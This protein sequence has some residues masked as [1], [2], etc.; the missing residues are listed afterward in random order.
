VDPDPA[1]FV[2]S[3]QDANKKTNLKKV[4][5]LLLFECKFISFLKD[6]KVQKKLKTVRSKVFLAIL[7]GGPKEVKNSKNQGFSY[8]FA[9]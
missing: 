6:K 7:L 8:Y 1:I 2:I 9:G 4:F 3:L 5:L